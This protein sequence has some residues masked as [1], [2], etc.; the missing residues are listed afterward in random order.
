MVKAAVFDMDHTLFDRYETIR[1]VIPQFMEHF[2]IAQGITAEFVY[3][4]LCWADRH[5]VHRG[6]EEIL[7][8]LCDAGVFA[9]APTYPEYEAFMLSCFKSVA[10]KFPFTESVLKELSSMGIRLGL[11]TNGSPEVQNRKID[12][13]GLREYM[14][15]IIISGDYPF[16]KP[17]TQIF[18]LMAERLNV[19]ASEMMYIGDHP[20]FDVE[21]SRKAGCIPVWVKTTGTWIFPEIEKP[22]LQVETIAEIPQ[23]IREGNV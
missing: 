11:I 14:E 22:A 12:M 7:G 5:F 6:W 3:E 9:D 17:D 16:K 4:N 23:I 8:H 13:L 18:T 20:L 2:N 10:V 19:D 21:G 1:T 15:E